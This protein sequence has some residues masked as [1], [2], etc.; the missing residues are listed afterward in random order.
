M[1]SGLLLALLAACGGDP[2]TG[3]GFLKPAPGENFVRDGLGPTG[4]LSA[5]VGVD[6]DFSDAT[7]VALTVG[8]RTLDLDANGDGTLDLRAAGAYTLTATAFDGD[9]EI[10]T[11]T[12]EITVTDLEL[13]TCREALDLYKID[14]SI[15]GASPGIEDPVTARMPINGVPYRVSGTANPRMTMLGDCRL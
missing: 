8:P 13:A 12:V 14:Y 3:F 2:G 1:R 15:A 7:R 10:A 9:T 11:D 5:L 4:A 6:V